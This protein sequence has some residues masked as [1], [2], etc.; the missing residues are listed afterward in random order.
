MK[1]QPLPTLVENLCASFNIDNDDRYFFLSVGAVLGIG[2]SF[3]AYS[4]CTRVVEQDN[5]IKTQV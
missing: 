4:F 2:L 1:T 3:C 5:Y